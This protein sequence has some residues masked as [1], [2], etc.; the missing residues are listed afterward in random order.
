MQ[1]SVGDSIVV[2]KKNYRF[3]R[4]SGIGKLAEAST[5]ELSFAMFNGFH[6]LCALRQGPYGVEAVNRYIEEFLKDAGLID[7]G[8]WYRGQPVMVTQNDYHL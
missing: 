8:A 5:I 3:D 1:T 6:V 2:F 4:E 7:P